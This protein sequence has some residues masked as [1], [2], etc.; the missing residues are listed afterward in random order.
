MFGYVQDLLKLA[1]LTQAQRVESLWPQQDRALSRGNGP[2]CTLDGTGPS[3]IDINWP[4]M[5]AIHIQQQNCNMVEQ[6]DL[7]M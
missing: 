3:T 7:D 4:L 6:A 5:F 1:A 2:G